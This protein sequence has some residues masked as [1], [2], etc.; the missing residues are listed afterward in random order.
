MSSLPSRWVEVGVGGAGREVREGGRCG[1]LYLPCGKGEVV[2][3]EAVTA[4]YS[5][6]SLF[7]NC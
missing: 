3:S 2:D 4:I 7:R 6:I 5:T 1:K